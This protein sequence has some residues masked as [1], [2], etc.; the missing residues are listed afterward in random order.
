MGRR[1]RGRCQCSEGRKRQGWHRLILTLEATGGGTVMF[2]PFRGFRGEGMLAEDAD[3]EV[4]IDC[5]SGRSC[6]A[7]SSARDNRTPPR[8]AV[9]R[10]RRGRAARPASGRRRS[11]RRCPPGPRRRSRPGRPGSGARAVCRSGSWVSGSR[12]PAAEY[13]GTGGPSGARS[14]AGSRSP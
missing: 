2:G 13:L 4:L 7:C 5:W 12:P 1:R 14:S 10:Y 3:V 6:T 11:R 9:T 8:Y